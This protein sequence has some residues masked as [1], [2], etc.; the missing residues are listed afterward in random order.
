MKETEQKIVKFTQ[1]EL[2]SR[3]GKRVTIPKAT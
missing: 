1:E 2:L 3:N